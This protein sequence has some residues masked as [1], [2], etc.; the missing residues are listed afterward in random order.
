[1]KT[2][3]AVIIQCRLSSTRF[4][5]KA[6]KKIGD[7]TILEWAMLSMSKV[8]ADRYFVATDEQSYPILKSICEKNNYECFAGDL[9]NVLKRYC[10]LIRKIN[11]DTVIR[12]T[13]DNPFLIYE[14]AVDSLN[15]FEKLNKEKIPCE[16]FT[17]SGLP[18]GCG[19]EIFNA[20]SLLMAQTTTVLPFDLEHVGP[21]LYNHQ[22]KY[23]CIFKKAP[24]RFNH[25]DLR[26]T[27]DTYTDYLRCI[28]AYNNLE[29]KEG[30][31]AKIKSAVVSEK[32]LAPVAVE[33]GIPSLLI[34]SHGEETSG[35]RNKPAILADCMEAI[36][37]AYYLDSGYKSVEK[38]VL[39]FI[40]PAVDNVLINGIGS[41]DYKSVLQEKYQK[42]TKKI[43]VYELISKTGPDHNQ[44]FTVVVHLGDKVFGPAKDF[45]KKEAEQK[46]AKIALDNL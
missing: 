17:Y 40:I 5:E 4:K 28:C 29:N 21:A 13:A 16:Y 24:E 14:A 9:N 46:A 27:V 45:S 25:P 18:H 33:F 32:A 36:I 1:M 23:K 11:V 41:K 6:L 2:K 30:D 42:L 38:F 43:P 31:L 10:D 34:L 39:E 35:G 7:K 44:E 3:R 19:V 15:E 12:A 22:D 8:P 26:T 37:G 20:Q